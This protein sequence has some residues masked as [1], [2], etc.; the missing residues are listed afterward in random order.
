MLD[1]EKFFQDRTNMSYFDVFYELTLGMTLRIDMRT[2][3]EKLNKLCVVLLPFVQDPQFYQ[4]NLQ[5]KTLTAWFWSEERLSHIYKESL[6]ALFYFDARVQ[7]KTP[8]DVM[9][10]YEAGGMVFLMERVEHLWT[11]QYYGSLEDTNLPTLPLRM[12]G[13]EG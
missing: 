13:D 12:E 8:I 4:D 2:E 5:Q 3:E 6:L 7:Q 10:K 9:K 1:Y 11:S